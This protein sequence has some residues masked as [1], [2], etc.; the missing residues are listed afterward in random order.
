[1]EDEAS[2]SDC[3]VTVLFPI[4]AAAQ[5]DYFTNWPAGSS[6][7]EVG[8]SVAEHFVT[9]PHQG[10]TI[11]YGEVGAWYRALAFAQLTSDAD[12]RERLIR[13]FEPLLPGGAETSL[14]RK[15]AHVDDEI[16]GI[17]SAGPDAFP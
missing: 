11:F 5:Q 13:R 17:V 7:Q 14:I 9:N 12:L 4:D 15:R 6:P 10:K 3:A 8:K 16:F 1:M 2:H